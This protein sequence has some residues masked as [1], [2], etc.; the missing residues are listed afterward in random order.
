MN[1]SD[2][3]ID[4]NETWKTS[5]IKTSRRNNNQRERD[6]VEHMMYSTPMKDTRD[7]EIHSEIHSDIHSDVYRNCRSYNS[8]SHDE[9]VATESLDHNM[10][11]DLIGVSCLQ[12]ESSLGVEDEGRGIALQP[13]RLYTMSDGTVTVSG[14]DAVLMKADK[15]DRNLARLTSSGQVDA[16]I[17][18]STHTRHF[19][20]RT[21]EAAV[22]TRVPI[23]GVYGPVLLDLIRSG[24]RVIG[25][26]DSSCSS[27]DESRAIFFARLLAFYW[28]DQCTYTF[29][30]QV[31]WTASRVAAMSL[32]SVAV[33]RLS[34]NLLSRSH[35]GNCETNMLLHEKCEDHFCVEVNGYVVPGGPLSERDLVSTVLPKKSPP[36]N[37]ATSSCSESWFANFNV[38]DLPLGR[39]KCAVETVLNNVVPL[40]L[41]SLGCA[42]WNDYVL[43]WLSGQSSNTHMPREVCYLLGAVTAAIFSHPPSKVSLPYISG[44]LCGTLWKLLSYYLSCHLSSLLSLLSIAI[45]LFVTSLLMNPAHIHFSTT[46]QWFGDGFWF[47]PSYLMR[48][49]SAEDTTL[50]TS[51]S[52]NILST[53]LLATVCSE[54]IVIPTLEHRIFVV[55]L[56]PALLLDIE[57]D[58]FLFSE[59]QSVCAACTP[60]AGVLCGVIL[61]SVCRTERAMKDVRSLDCVVADSRPPQRRL[62]GDSSISVSDSDSSPDDPPGALSYVPTPVACG[63]HDDVR[64]LATTE[65]LLSS[66]EISP[67]EV[68]PN[69]VTETLNHIRRSILSTVETIYRIRACTCDWLYVRYSLKE[70]FYIFRKKKAVRLCVGGYSSIQ[71]FCL[72]MIVTDSSGFLMWWKSIVPLS[73][74]PCMNLIVARVL[75]SFVAFLLAFLTTILAELLSK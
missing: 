52:A 7:S 5:P 51:Q 8:R 23:L 9:H 2:I 40:A 11:V 20:R 15:E 6:R 61:I 74:S 75:I 28:R 50:G 67:V 41:S 46:L 48:I 49:C 25:C 29:P 16:V 56:L 12:Q 43:Y 57:K 13:S 1:I 58:D 68:K 60:I 37:F 4:T 26:Y 71:C 19:H 42:Q 21:L 27:S 3:S 39:L 32:F 44:A 17:C 53:L 47:V 35:P 62:S 34:S 65:V 64:V 63:V 10:D 45:S 36:V 14:P 18:L 55:L 38:V 22:R 72:L 30:S 33:L 59:T 70:V 69:W 73:C 24:G 54:L 66:P 31:P